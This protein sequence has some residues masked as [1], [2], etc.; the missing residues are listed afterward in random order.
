MPIY[1]RGEFVEAIP[2]K[3]RLPVRIPAAPGFQIGIDPRTLTALELIVLTG[4][5][6]STLSSR[7]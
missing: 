2:E 6:S 5:V 1:G 4:T 7:K 3:E